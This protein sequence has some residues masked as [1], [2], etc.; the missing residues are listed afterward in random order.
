MRAL[1]P[2]LFGLLLLWTPQALLAHGIEHAMRDPRGLPGM[3]RPA[4]LCSCAGGEAAAAL[5]RACTL[6]A[7]SCRPVGADF[8]G[9]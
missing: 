7:G 1:R 4:G 2:L 6:G 3:P 5:H 9:R 8:R